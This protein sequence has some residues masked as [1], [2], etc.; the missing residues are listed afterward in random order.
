MQ[1]IMPV[2]KSFS[3]RFYNIKNTQELT[4]KTRRKYRTNWN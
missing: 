2:K 4:Y 3:M 1:R